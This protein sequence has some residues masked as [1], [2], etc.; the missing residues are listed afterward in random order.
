MRLAVDGLDGEVCDHGKFDPPT[1][2]CMA[3]TASLQSKVAL[4]LPIVT[5][6]RR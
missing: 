4:P 1:A 2:G 3:G 6:T 5:T